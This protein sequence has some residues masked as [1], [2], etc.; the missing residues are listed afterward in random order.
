M[1]PLDINVKISPKSAR[2]EVVGTLADGT[3]RVKVAAAPEK[4]KA[5]EELCNVMAKHFG[6]PRSSVTILAGATSQR[7]RIRIDI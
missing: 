4:G 6:V 2:S 7:K 1:P 5:N 3:L